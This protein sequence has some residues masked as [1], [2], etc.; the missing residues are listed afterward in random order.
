M[1]PGKQVDD[2]TCRGV[3]SLISPQIVDQVYRKI[4]VDVEAHSNDAILNP[5]M[6]MN[7]VLGWLGESL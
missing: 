6:L 3:M 1:N 2:L 5:L 4:T 7:G